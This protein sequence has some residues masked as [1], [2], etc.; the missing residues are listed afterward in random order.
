MADEILR[1]IAI[2]YGWPDYRPQEKSIAPA[3][4][5]IL[6][7][8]AGVYHFPNGPMVT[9]VVEKNRIWVK[10]PGADKVEIFPE[11]ATSFFSLTGGI[12]PLRFVLKD[13]KSVELTAGGATAKRQ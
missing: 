9:I 4:E 8:Y 13:D 12:P 7:A 6:R 5:E 3:G 10:P 1:S 11:S 2:E